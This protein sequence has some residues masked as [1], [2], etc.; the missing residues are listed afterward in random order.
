VIG[1]VEGQ[2]FKTAMKVLNRGRL[3]IAAF[4]VGQAQR[5]CDEATA[6]CQGRAPNSASPSPSISWCR[7][8]WPTVVHETYAGRC[9]V[10]ETARGA[11]MRANA[12]SSR[13]RAASCSVPKW[14]AASPTAPCRSMAGLRLHAG[15]RRSSTFYR[16]VRLFRLY[17]GTSQIQQIIIA[18]EMCAQR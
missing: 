4:C 17:E 18:R 10:M 16:D 7:R 14:W 11:S 12:S 8:C 9:M 15:L 5:L 3:H 1:G 2:G 13:P 6:L